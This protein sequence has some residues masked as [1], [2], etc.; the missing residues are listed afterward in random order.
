[1]L[2]KIVAVLCVLNVV[3]VYMSLGM[4]L[5]SEVL[6][7]LKYLLE[8]AQ[9]IFVFSLVGLLFW[10]VSGIMYVFYDLLFKE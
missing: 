5:I 8:Y 9:L 3:L 10:F 7:P 4:A 2:V 1:M 6:P